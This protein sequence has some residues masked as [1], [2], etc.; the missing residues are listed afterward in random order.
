MLRDG[1]GA[2][3]SWVLQLRVEAAPVQQPLK[4]RPQIVIEFRWL[5]P[6]RENK[7][8]SGNDFVIAV[9]RK[10]DGDVAAHVGALAEERAR[11]LRA[12]RQRIAGAL[13]E[14]TGVQRCFS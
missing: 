7:P 3:E 9:G 5:V 12:R 13:I 2:L 14:H 11:L 1:S 10:P 4:L 6:I 8:R